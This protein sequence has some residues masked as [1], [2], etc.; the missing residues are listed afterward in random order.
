MD[1]DNTRK[2]PEQRT[3]PHARR[4]FARQNPAIYAPIFVRVTASSGLALEGQVM[5]VAEGGVGVWFWH[6]GE[7][8]F[9]EGEW[10]TLTLQLPRVGCGELIGRAAQMRFRRR[11]FRLGIEVDTPAPTPSAQAAIDALLTLVG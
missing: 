10:V 1:Q 9:E 11:G 3:Q 5:D 7:V 6:S 2:T 8:P 4:R